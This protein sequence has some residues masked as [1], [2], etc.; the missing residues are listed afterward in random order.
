MSDRRRCFNP[1]PRVGG[2]LQRRRG[3]GARGRVSIHAPAWGATPAVLSG[4]HAAAVS[5]HAPAWGATAT[6]TRSTRRHACFN[7]RPRVGG[8]PAPRRRAGRH[9]VSIHA[10][11][12]GATAAVQIAVLDPSFQ[13]TPPR[14]GRPACADNVA[15]T[16]SCF[17]PRPRVGGDRRHR[18][19]A[20]AGVVSIHAPAWGATDQRRTIGRTP[21]VSIHAPAW[22]ATSRSARR[23]VRHVSIH[24]PAWGATRRI[25]RVAPDDVSIHAPAWGATAARPWPSTRLGFN[26]RP[27]VGGDSPAATRRHRGRVSIHAP[28]WGATTQRF[29]TP[30]AAMFQSTPPRGGRP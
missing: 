1:R 9:P 6:S 28:A 19:P 30:G 7:P 17:N 18:W 12:W 23:P 24:A 27:R 8:D 25:R 22:G 20:C 11:A 10:P 4:T 15:S 16:R 2:D 13:S 26:P 29:T 3:V 21:D 5:I 14:G